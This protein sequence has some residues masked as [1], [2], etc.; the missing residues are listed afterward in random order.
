MATEELDL[1]GLF[2]M[3]ASVPAGGGDPCMDRK[4]IT[5]ALKV[6]LFFITDSS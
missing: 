6:P 2:N 4:E 1:V 3:F 5:R